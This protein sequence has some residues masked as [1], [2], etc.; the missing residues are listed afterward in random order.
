MCVFSFIFISSFFCFCKSQQSRPKATQA[1]FEEGVSSPAHPERMPPC[2]SPVGRP[3]TAATPS[4]PDLGV[5]LPHCQCDLT[6]VFLCPSGFEGLWYLEGKSLSECGS[7]LFKGW[8]DGTDARHKKS[9]S[10]KEGGRSRT[11]SGIP[12]PGGKQS[13]RQKPQETS[14]GNRRTSHQLMGGV[15]TGKRGKE[16]IDGGAEV[17][18]KHI[19]I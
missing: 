2:S 16:E 13:L 5:L 12:P 11:G 9:L 17:E 15:G 1:A 10:R 18:G 14:G 8:D 4:H 3:S 19:L 6:Q 7:S